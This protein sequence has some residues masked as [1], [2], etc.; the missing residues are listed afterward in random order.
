MPPTIQEYEHQDNYYAR[1]IE[2]STTD[3]ASWKFVLIDGRR[4]SINF[5]ALDYY[6]PLRRLRTYVESHYDENITLAGAA[7][8]ACLERKYLS[9][10]FRRRVGV[11]FREWL[12]SYRV[13]QAIRLIESEDFSLTSV[14]ERVGFQDLRTFERNFKRCTGKTPRDWKREQSP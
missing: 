8:I 10:L 14:S 3:F 7:R 5:R 6:I 4:E 12:A 13:Q 11:T 9:A 2:I 1:R